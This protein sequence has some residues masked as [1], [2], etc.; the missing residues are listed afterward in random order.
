[1]ETFVRVAQLGSF[2]AAARALHVTPSAVSKLLARLEA[3]LGAQLFQRSTRKVELTLEG[4]LFFA[5]SQLVLEQLDAAE[6]EVARTLEPRGR[7][8][9]NC[10][11]PFGLHCLL[12]QL[13]SFLASHRQISVEVTLSDSVVDPIAAHA[14]LTIRTGPL[15]ASA[16]VAHRLG[17]S[18]MLVVAAPSYL[19]R[20]GEPKTPVELGKHNLLGFAFK[21]HVRGWPF[22]QHGRALSVPVIGNAQVSDGEAMRV[23]ALQ[24][25]GIARLASFHVAADIE[26]GQLVPLLER[27]NAEKREPIS[28]LFAG[29]RKQ[30]PARVRALLDHLSIH[31]VLAEFPA[32][33]AAPRRASKP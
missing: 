32:R 17:D 14:D 24:G 3:R 11:V 7:V 9:V 22:L 25:A 27:F 31:L 21:R 12:P 18:R 29:P 28:A 20:H 19:E 30:M 10:N 13:P 1:M 33:A 6:K 2:S 26:S 5:R 23:L 15:R 8:R 4:E 16:L